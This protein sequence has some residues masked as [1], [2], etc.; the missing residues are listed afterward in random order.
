MRCINRLSKLR[1][2]LTRA[3]IIVLALVISACAKYEYHETRAT[4][5]AT[6]SPQQEAAMSEDH[7]LDVGVVL[8]EDGVDIT[9][10]ESAAYSS[11]R[12]SEA[13]WFS[14][15]LKNTLA[16]S[17]A[18]GSVRTLPKQAIVDLSISGRLIE[19]NGEVVTL[20]I[21]AEDATG[22]VWLDKEY[23]Q[24]AS[25]Y[26]Y[27][28][29]I[30]L[31]GDPFQSLFNE[32]ANDLF[33]YRA[34]LSGQQ[35]TQIRAIAKIR[36]AKDFVPAA[37]DG[38]V[39]QDQDG[40]YQLLRLP[41]QS[42]PMLL[43][44]EQV[45]ARNDLFLDVIQDYYRVFNRNMA[46]PYAE[47]RKLSYK[48]VIYERQLREQARNEKIV[49]A[50]VM[51]GGT[52]TAVDDDRSNRTRVAGHVGIISGAALF[53]RSFAKRDEAAMHSDALREL[54]ASL[55]AQLEPSVVDLQDRSVTLSGTV[56]DQLKE[57]RRI[58]SR[59]FEV[60]QGVSVP[61]PGALQ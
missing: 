26:A 23:H 14:S 6:I 36:F 21:K 8:F 27:H 61:L 44:V 25:S 13:V 10:D 16:S 48:E 18:W 47:W 50:L 19:S 9:D 43:R 41:A 57:W 38:Y 60:E 45:Q 52:A 22:R 40:Q 42:D 5:I 56:D 1:E 28:P 15:Q 58:L 39:T 49:G 31:P 35:L 54:G 12:Q 30:D 37:F 3:L 33:A 24:Q 32:I 11:V 53:S 59:M 7:L 46:E 2:P 4:E 34:N 29:E 17:N 55:Q 51:L 20:A